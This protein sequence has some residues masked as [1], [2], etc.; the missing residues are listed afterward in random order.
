MNCKTGILVITNDSNISLNDDSHLIN[1]YFTKCEITLNLNH[2]KMKNEFDKKI[3]Q[4]GKNLYISLLLN[5]NI[6]RWF[7]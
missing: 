1:T 3:S 4:D 2:L 5:V 7:Y 6:S